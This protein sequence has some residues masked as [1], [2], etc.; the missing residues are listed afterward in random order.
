MLTPDVKRRAVLEVMAD[1]E[2][3]ARRACNLAGLDRST[4]QYEKKRAGDDPLR[5]RLKAL[6]GKRRRF[7]YRRLGILLSQEGHQELARF[8]WTG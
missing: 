1:H 4:F 5:E 7:G 3:S 2:V 6:A 8:V